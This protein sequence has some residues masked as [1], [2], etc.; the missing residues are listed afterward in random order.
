M[1]TNEVSTA[2]TTISHFENTS[3]VHNN[4][5][6]VALD[7]TTDNEQNLQPREEE[8]NKI[9]TDRYGFYITD[10]S[11]VAILS[12]SEAKK[13]AEKEQERIKKWVKMINN[14]DISLTK[15]AD[16]LKRRI[17]KGIPDPCRGEVWAKLA[18]INEYKNK[19]PKAFAF[20]NH[21]AS[22]S[23][24]VADEIERDLDRTFPRHELFVTRGGRGQESL[25]RVLQSYAVLDPETG[26]CQGMG[27]VAAMFL[28]YM[29]EEDA[30]YSLLSA[31]QVCCARYFEQ[32]Y[33]KLHILSYFHAIAS[34]SVHLPLSGKCLCPTSHS[35]NS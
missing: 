9:G 17:R 20:E 4:E 35:S 29:A 31:M 22:I 19:F 23:Q 14:W 8:I 34:S 32:P 2:S 10:V 30:F 15:K 16:K 11:R 13:Y 5:H 25:R 33:Y 18:H 24:F 1:D 21:S 26:Y 3:T 7:V 12:T 6:V 27:F 28:M